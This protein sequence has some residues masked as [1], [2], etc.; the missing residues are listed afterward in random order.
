MM[1]T[2]SPEGEGKES[3][4]PALYN[5]FR[6]GCQTKKDFTTPALLW[7]PCLAGT[8]RGRVILYAMRV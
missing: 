6:R 1:M 2:H 5:D 3:R 7:S 4:F 8:E